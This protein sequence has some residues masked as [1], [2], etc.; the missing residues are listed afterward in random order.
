[1]PVNC[2]EEQTEVSSIRFGADCAQSVVELIERQC[3]LTPER[4]AITCDGKELTYRE[5]ER[6]S[7]QLANHLRKR[8]AGP[9][10]VV[11]FCVRRSAAMLVGLLGV[12]KTGAAYVPLDPTYPE[13]RLA[14][15]LKDCEAK[16]VITERATR[17]VLAEL[18]AEL[19]CLDAESEVIEQEPENFQPTTIGAEALVYLIYTSGSTGE[20]KGVMITHGSLVNLLRSMAHEPGLASS[21]VMLAITTLSFD[22][23]ALELYL[24]LTRGARVVIAGPGV[25]RDPVRL[26]S[27]LEDSGATVTQATPATWRMLVDSGWRGNRRLKILCGGEMLSR[28]LKD[29]LLNRAASVWNLYGPTE[30]TV[31]STVERVEKGSGLVTIGHPIENTEIYIL[32]ERGDPVPIGATGELYIGGAGLALGYWKRPKVTDER[33]VANRFGPPGSRLY[34]TGDEARYLLDGRIDYLGRKDTQ[35][36]IRGHR[37][38]LGEIEMALRQHPAVSDSVVVA[39]PIGNSEARLIAYTVAAKSDV[40]PRQDELRGHLLRIL[41]EYML[42]AFFVSL[43]QLPLTPNGKIDRGALPL[44]PTEDVAGRAQFVAPRTD[45]ER[46]L[47]KIFE[48]ILEVR[49]ISISDSFFDLGGNSLLAVRLFV[50]IAKVFGRDLPLAAIF[51]APSVECLAGLLAGEA[52]GAGWSPLVPIKTTGGLPPLFCVHSRGS[53]VLRYRALGTLLGPEQPF[54][55]LQPRGLD[56]KSKPHLHIEDMAADYIQAIQTIQPE[57]PYYLGGVCLGGIIA[58]EMA[59]QLA[60]KNQRVALLALLDSEFPGEAKYLP[61]G[62]LRPSFLWR[63]DRELGQ[64]LRRSPA[65]VPAYGLARLRDLVHRLRRPKL[66]EA[67]AK[68]IEA[69]TRAELTYVPKPFPGRLQLFCCAEWSFRAYQDKRWC[70]S[71]VAEGVEVHLVPGNH[72]SMM[73][74]PNVTIVAEKLRRSLQAS[75]RGIR[76][77]RAQIN[78]PAEHSELVFASA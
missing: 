36:K 71:E 44:P 54:W 2:N 1:M 13:Q 56:G 5:L 57:G 50:E 22:I 76:T 65:Q 30:T 41:P 62:A 19:I 7:N 3:E 25:A 33:F 58:F 74:P 35:V 70:W 45:A 66:P 48:R 31:W 46:Q 67:L 27:L 34:R 72:M 32:D 16:L 14:F 21:D 4:I 59:Q 17:E 42:P 39:R 75:R 11:A 23:A 38:E 26:R 49:P 29:A 68:V 77:A 73:E 60:A 24:P 20:P 6:R 69:N 52:S 78:S 43:P 8:N 18:G 53:S 15:M 55:G 64:F 47:T 28:D 40:L 51:Q 63:L 37:I 12:L 10:I 61:P 9:G